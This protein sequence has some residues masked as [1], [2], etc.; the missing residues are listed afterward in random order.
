MRVEVVNS[1][2]VAWHKKRTKERKALDMIPMRVGEENSR[3]PLSLTKLALHQ[4]IAQLADTCTR[5]NDDQ[6]FRRLN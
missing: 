4:G 1:E 3:F 6:I 2:V 5:V